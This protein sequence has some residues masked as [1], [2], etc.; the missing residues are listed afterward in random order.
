[1]IFD[2]RHGRHAVDELARRAGATANG[3]VLYQRAIPLL[4][5][6]PQI[7]TEIGDKQYTGAVVPQGMK[8]R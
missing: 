7:G 8:P 6:L 1:L 4:E 3:D 2:N 5:I